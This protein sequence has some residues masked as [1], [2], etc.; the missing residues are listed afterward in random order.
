MAQRIV[1]V[2]DSELNRRVL[3]HILGELDDVAVSTFA[4]GAEALAA[5]Q[6]L[7]PS[8]FVI[9]YRM[10]TPNGLELLAQIR[11]SPQMGDVPVVMV[12]AAE[13]RAVC[14]EALE[15]GVS[16]FIVRPLDP[17]EFLRRAGNLLA[18]ERARRAATEHLRRESSAARINASR[19][20]AIWRSGAGAALDDESYFRE[21]LG[22][23][24]K[25]I[26]AGDDS[27]GLVGMVGR[28]DGDQIV[29]QFAGS[30][31]P[32]S[33][34]KPGFCYAIAPFRD[35]I[36]EGRAGGYVDRPTSLADRAEFVS[37]LYA[38]FQCG[39]ARYFVV[40][41]SEHK[42]GE[43][44]TPL[45]VEFVETIASLCAARLDQRAQN[46]RLSYQMAHDTLTGLPNRT[47][48]RQHAHAAL[49]HDP[50][51]ALLVLN[52]D[53][54]RLVNDTLGHQTGDALLVEVGA[55]LAAVSD[56][57]ELVARLGG[58]S[59]SI[60]TPHCKS[61]IQGAQAAR[62]YLR[63]FQY[64]FATGD[65]ANLER[66]SLRA[67]I[68]IA[69]APEDG[70]DFGQLLARAD[71]ACYTAKESGR[72]SF[73]FFDRAVE[74]TFASQ[75]VMQDEL[76]AALARNEFVLHYQPHV[77]IATR[78]ITGAEA[79]IRWR[80]PTRGTLEPADFIPF[81]ERC[82]LA[83]AIGAWVMHEAAE[84]ARLWRAQYPD[85]QLW[86][87]MSVAELRDETLAA[88]IRE[89][90]DVH[91]LGV[92]ITESVAMENLADAMK[93][94]K[95]LR[96]LGM[97]VA[98][99]DFGTGHSSLAQLKRLPLD[100]VKIDRA[101]IGGLPADRR[102]TAVVNAVISLANSYGLVTVAEGIETLEQADF[103]Q[104]AG[105]TIGQGFL[106][107][108]AVPFAEFGALL[109]R[110]VHAEVAA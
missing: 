43:P 82:G 49:R 69:M 76:A 60:F 53:D 23:A 26:T 58:D 13:E 44:F 19:L 86:F 14:Y 7:D 36:D 95:T 35:V 54:F 21:L 1:I 73:G 20:D 48:L 25:C 78:R 28:L 94:M 99:D 102:D 18:I 88:R 34:F 104:A 72:G 31:D 10:P 2:D 93:V 40:F 5:A 106:Y 64:P 56:E 33:E 9:D 92:E 109:V 70:T 39:T 51:A 97:R 61:R 24:A 98:L 4:G 3:A 80:H 67:S 68:G 62:R 27:V 29:V 45:D 42:R 30:G 96:E 16:D 84:A 75:R 79:L 41:R 66:L 107:G 105:C 8:L 91:G 83:G 12:T 63:A 81:A 101:F 57:E 85:F 6:A 110:G 65:R 108:K 55:R 89:L 37:G 103:L 71:A 22:K 11:S 59:F 87:N 32:A 74:E 100:V 17:G 15:K 46:D 38:P 47:V 90:G 50:N 77:D 52:I